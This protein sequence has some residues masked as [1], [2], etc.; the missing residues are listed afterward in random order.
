MAALVAEHHTGTMQP[1]LV[2]L[3][4]LG[5]EVLV[6]LLQVLLVSVLVAAAVALVQSVVIQMQV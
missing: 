5:K 2:V 1:L 3:E 6:V 4:H